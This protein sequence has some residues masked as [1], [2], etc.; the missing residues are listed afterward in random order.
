MIGY[1]LKNKSFHIYDAYDY[2]F[3]S[4]YAKKKKKKKNSNFQVQ[5]YM[6][7]YIYIYIWFKIK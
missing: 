3:C 7:T 2:I 6:N 4:S 5:I 1:L